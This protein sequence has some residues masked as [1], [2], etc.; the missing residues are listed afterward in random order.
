M[1]KLNINHTKIA[2]TGLEALV[3][4]NVN[5]IFVKFIF[6]PE[7]DNL[8]RVAVFTNGSIS[9][10]VSLASDTCAIP[11]EVLAGEGELF[12]SM[13]GTINDGELVICTENEFLGRIQ[14]SNANGNVVE[15]GEATPTVIDTLLADVAELKATGGGSGEAGTDGADGKSAYELAVENGFEGTVA[16]WLASLKGVDGQDGADGA[17][18]HT[19]VKGLDYFTAEDVAQIA[20][21]ASA[22][23]SLDSYALKTY[24]DSEITSA[25]GDIDA[26][27]GNG[28]IT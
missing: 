21:A 10:A 8:S 11:W 18:G 25:I 20:L 24:V 15:A 9:I 16:E 5:S 13:R 28:V 14:P 22:L 3:E 27:I 26:L 19:P 4:G 1:I 2:A 23:V 17:E 7:W 12:V 6:S